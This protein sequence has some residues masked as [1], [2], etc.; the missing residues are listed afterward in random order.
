MVDHLK[1][2]MQNNDKGLLIDES[3]EKDI[4]DV[5]VEI[6]DADKKGLE[7]GHKAED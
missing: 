3:E 2:K 4:K 7:G 6:K 5:E 1:S